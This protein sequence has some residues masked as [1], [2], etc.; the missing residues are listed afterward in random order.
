MKSFHPLVLMV[1]AIGLGFVGAANSQDGLDRRVTYIEVASS[2]TETAADLLRNYASSSS[3][4]PGNQFV[5]ALQRSGRSNHFVLVEVWD[6]EAAQRFNAEADEN[7]AVFDVLGRLLI[8]PLDIRLHYDLLSEGMSD[9]ENEGVYVVT[10]I[11]VGPPSRDTAVELLNELV[12]ASR[13]EAGNA[14]FDVWTTID[15]S[16]HMTALEVWESAAVRNDHVT[17]LHTKNFRRRLS[18]HNGALYDERIYHAL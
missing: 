10:H 18:P 16:N 17:S 5:L 7:V 8:T 9:V 2:A 1:G 11:D 3:E 15:R 12:P 6:D 4:A 13:S 14:G